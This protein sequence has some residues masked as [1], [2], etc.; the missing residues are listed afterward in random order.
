MDCKFNF[1]PVGQ[2]G[3]TSCIF[4]ENSDV[5]FS[6]I[7]D[8]GSIT[9]GNYLY[10]QI[11]YAQKELKLSNSK[12]IID[13]L[14]ISHFDDDHISGIQE[15]LLGVHCKVLVIP[16]LTIAERLTIFARNS[17]KANWYI[18]F[19]QN[20][21]LFFQ[22]GEY[23]IDKII[24]VDWDNGWNE[25]EYLSIDIESNNLVSNIGSNTPRVSQG[26]I[27]FDT[28][29]IY[30]KI[31]F[32]LKVTSIDFEFKFYIQPFDDKAIKEF[33]DSIKLR[34][35]NTNINLLFD[36]KHLSILKLLYKKAFKNINKTSL[37][38]SIKDKKNRSPHYFDKPK[39]L[40]FSYN[41]RKSG[42]IF[43]GDSFLKSK[44]STKRFFVIIIKKR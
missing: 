27:I 6:F 31:P 10:Q 17:Q 9:S 19:L 13:L 15:L 44:K 36:N 34:F 26:E 4:Q 25:K 30:M 20:P 39:N 1:R 12:R 40:L 37:C 3:F 41:S 11:E 23:E 22:S 43:T 24:F 8:C 18:Q 5:I 29:F 16:F 33:E 28:R 42:L 2:G 38:V 32:S 7:Y 14:V 21:K 35:P